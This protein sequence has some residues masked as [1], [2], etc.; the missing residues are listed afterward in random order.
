MNRDTK[1]HLLL[2]CGFSNLYFN[3]LFN[4]KLHY[5][6][7]PKEDLK[8]KKNRKQIF[9]EKLLLGS[10]NLVIIFFLIC[11]FSSRFC[12]VH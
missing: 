9:E 1:R 11:S 10:K 4:Y 3:F 12:Y 5:E 8:K 6:Q 7:K 2:V